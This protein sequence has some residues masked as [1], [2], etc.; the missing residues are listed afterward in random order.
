MKSDVMK[1]LVQFLHLSMFFKI[2]LH[3]YCS[4]QTAV[5]ILKLQTRVVTETERKWHET[6]HLKN[7]FQGLNSYLVDVISY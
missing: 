5:K 7:K 1:I 6:A 2:I 4:L 3:K